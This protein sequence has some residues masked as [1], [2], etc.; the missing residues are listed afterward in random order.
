MKRIVT[1][2]V[3]AL[4]L[5]GTASADSKHQQRAANAK[6]PDCR[7]ISSPEQIRSAK[8]A[9]AAPAVAFAKKHHATAMPA[10]VVCQSKRW[11]ALHGNVKVATSKRLSPDRQRAKFRFA[12]R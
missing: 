2:A 5:I 10:S 9:N 12:C 11:Q 7:G 3:L 4:G 6:L 1:G 8:T